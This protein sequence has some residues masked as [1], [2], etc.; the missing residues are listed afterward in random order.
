MLTI[1][2]TDASYDRTIKKAGISCVIRR[3]TNKNSSQYNTYTNFISCTDSNLAELEALKFATSKLDENDKFLLIYMDNKPAIRAVK[4]PNRE[5]F[6]VE[7][8]T[9][10]TEIRQVLNKADIFR[11]RHVKGHVLNEIWNT[12]LQ[13]W[14]DS[15][16]RAALKRQRTQTKT[17][18]HTR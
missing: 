13:S 15:Q 8:S 6:S 10:A 14:C 3:R 16:A 11:L 18:P 12:K 9:L 1:I 5:E 4:R 7:K 17:N 2:Y